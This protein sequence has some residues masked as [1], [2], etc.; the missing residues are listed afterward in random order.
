G[1]EPPD[2]ACTSD[3][4]APTKISLSSSPA[5]MGPLWSIPYSRR[6][7]H[8]LVP[9]ASAIVGIPT[10]L[11]PEGP[12]HGRLPAQPGG[13]GNPAGPGHHPLLDRRRPGQSMDRL[14][15]LGGWQQCPRPS[16]GWPQLGPRV[17]PMATATRPE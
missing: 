16:P 6:Y 11:Q 12:P 13:A 5:C 17:Q 4:V 15:E 7:F 10:N 3:Q 14:A 2:L 1:R 9:Q 8:V